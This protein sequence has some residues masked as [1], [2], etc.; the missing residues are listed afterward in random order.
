MSKAPPPKP[1]PVAAAVK[2]LRG[3]VE[4]F[5]AGTHTDSK[6]R[7]ITFSHVDVDQMI[8]N[9]QLGA[10]PA[11][12]GHPKDTAPAYAQVE[13]YKREG[14]SLFAKFTK[15]NP[16]FEAGVESGAYFNRSVSVFKD[17]QRGWRVRHVGWLGA[18]PPAIDGLQPVEF[19]A[20]DENCF[21]FSAP[22]YSLVW[23]LESAA[24]LMR[25]L[26]D[27]MIEKDGLEAA[28]AT[29]PQWEIDSMNESVTSAR[30]QFND[31][32]EEKT[33]SLFNQNPG[34]PMTI[35]QAD[36]DKAVADART[37][38]EAAG[39]TAAEAATQ[40]QFAAQAAELLTLKK[41]QQKERIAAQIKVWKDKGQIVPADE[42]GLAEYMASLEDAGQ[43]F[44]F[45]KA[46]GGEAK[47]TPLQFFS[48]FMSARK[49]VVKL[50]GT[51]QPAPDG[52]V[53]DTTDTAAV[54]KAASDFMAAES[55]EGR[56]VSSA[57]AVQHV[58]R[59]AAAAK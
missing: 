27:R 29:L 38:G 7:Q 2:G 43:E 28:D 48:D 44:S 12:I 33:P 50:G 53:L 46:E 58:I 17:G 41:G 20:A 40:A 57:S 34:E 31:D 56:V 3:F 35:T 22:G 45:S 37:A 13:E 8:A 51:G 39:K 11:V 24:R 6:G 19:S 47:K 9:H 1:T 49:P 25:K 4:V 14:D 59:T 23:G 16:A 54:S 42:D 32:N 52:D 15:I 55:K 5:K 36:L 26:R 18:A 10:A 21:E 30:A